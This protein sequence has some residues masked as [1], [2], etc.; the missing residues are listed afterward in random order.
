MINWN[1]LLAFAQCGVYEKSVAAELEK[2]V[3]TNFNSD[4]PWINTAQEIL[5]AKFADIMGYARDLRVF[6]DP[7]AISWAINYLWINSNLVA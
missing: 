2:L 7:D 5:K 6:T 4:D 1:V 3:Y